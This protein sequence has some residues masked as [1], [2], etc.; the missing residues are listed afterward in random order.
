MR[1]L[2]DWLREVLRN[3]DPDPEILGGIPGNFKF[4]LSLDDEDTSGI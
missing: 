1:V 3:V 4:N 2:K